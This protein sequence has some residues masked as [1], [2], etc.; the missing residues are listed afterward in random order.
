[1]IQNEADVFR[2]IVMREP[3]TPPLFLVDRQEVT[4]GL[5]PSV[6]FVRDLFVPN[7]ITSEQ[8][9]NQHSMILLGNIIRGAQKKIQIA[10]MA[11]TDPM[12]TYQ[13]KAASKGGSLWKY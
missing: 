11:W 6:P 10:M 13:I 9:I 12:L 1:M 4:F 7:V 3:F 5:L 2:G 8:T